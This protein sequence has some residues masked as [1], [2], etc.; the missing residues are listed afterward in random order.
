LYQHHNIKEKVVFGFYAKANIATC[1]IVNDHGHSDN[2][3][4][5][6]GPM[7]NGMFG[8]YV[9]FEE[10][11]IKIVKQE[12]TYF[13]QHRRYNM[14]TNMGYVA[15]EHMLKFMSLYDGAPDIVYDEDKN[16]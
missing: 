12:N 16:N 1:F 14:D 7:Y 15:V 2:G 9:D 5:L 8:L 13:P 3:Y 4:L 6:K 10:N 11:C